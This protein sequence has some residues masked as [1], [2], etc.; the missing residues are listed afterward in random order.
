MPVIVALGVETILHN[1][2]DEQQWQPSVTYNQSVNATTEDRNIIIFQEN[3]R[4]DKCLNVN[5]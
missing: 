5:K 3:A 1:I 2:L 4:Y